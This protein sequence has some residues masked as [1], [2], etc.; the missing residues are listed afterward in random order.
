MPLLSRAVQQSV[1]QVQGFSGSVELDPII[2]DCVL[3]VQRYLFQ[4]RPEAYK[5]LGQSVMSRLLNLR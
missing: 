4:R 2:A 3:A 1:P 5:A